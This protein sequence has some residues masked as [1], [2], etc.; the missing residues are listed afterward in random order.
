M[1]FRKQ[2]GAC[3]VV[4]YSD[5]D[6]R[7][8]KPK[9]VKPVEK[10][11]EGLKEALAIAKGE[12]EPAKTLRAPLPKKDSE[13][14]KRRPIRK[15]PSRPRPKVRPLTVREEP[16]GDWL[17]KEVAEASEQPN[18]KVAAVC[19]PET[20]KPLTPAERT[21]RW[22][23]N[24][25]EKHSTYMKQYAKDRRA[26]SSEERDRAR[27]EALRARFEGSGDE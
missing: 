4:Y 12:A 9:R 20:K 3:G 23:E 7:C 11:E 19:Q 21:R 10:I 18:P 14:P 24:N 17:P 6:H 5:E 16:E 1:A 26:K 2:C 27:Y 15:P 8:V 13:E 22:R 25:P